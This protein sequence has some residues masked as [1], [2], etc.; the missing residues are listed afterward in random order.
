[1]RFNKNLYVNDRTINIPEVEDRINTGQSILGLYLICICRGD[2]LF[3]IVHS[4]HIHKPYFTRKEYTVIGM[5][6]GRDECILIVKDIIAK[7]IYLYKD[8]N[9]AKLKKRMC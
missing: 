6:Y 3:E 1:M 7:Y 5:A 8:M 2:N 9:F 4:I